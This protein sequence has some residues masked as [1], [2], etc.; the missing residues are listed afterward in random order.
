MDTRQDFKSSRRSVSQPHPN[1]RLAP[2][3][4]HGTPVAQGGVRQIKIMD[5][6]YFKSSKKE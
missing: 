4:G 1:I 3:F 6:E 2:F 5:F